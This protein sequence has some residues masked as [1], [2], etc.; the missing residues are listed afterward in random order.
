MTIEEIQIIDAPMADADFWM[1]VAIGT[2]G[3]VAIGIAIFL[4]C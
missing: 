2:S 3:T 4:I 1:G